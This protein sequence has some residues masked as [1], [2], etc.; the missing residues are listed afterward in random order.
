M[1]ALHLK[2]SAHNCAGRDGD[3]PG[4][5]TRASGHRSRLECHSRCRWILQV[6]TTYL[7][8]N[9]ALPCISMCLCLHPRHSESPNLPED[10]YTCMYVYIYM[11][12]Y[13]GTYVLNMNTY[14]RIH[15]PH[16]SRGRV[17]AFW[18]KLRM[19]TG[20]MHPYKATS[21]F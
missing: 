4:C 15:T 9:L 11:H 5:K 19:H 13:I 10:V 20:P 18:Q 2:T 7:R 3:K 8:T 16:T 21:V 17:P 14:I 6:S 12:V 1:A